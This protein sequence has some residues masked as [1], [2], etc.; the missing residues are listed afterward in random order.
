MHFAFEEKEKDK[1][2]SLAC[3]VGVVSHSKIPNDLRIH[4]LL[5]A[6]TSV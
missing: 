6:G 1:K 2:E 3:L 5:F 4:F